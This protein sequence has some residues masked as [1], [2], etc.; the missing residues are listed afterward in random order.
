MP[1][2]SKV[3]ITAILSRHNASTAR[4]ESMGAHWSNTGPLVGVALSLRRHFRGEFQ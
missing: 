4:V 1:H 3:R 2:R